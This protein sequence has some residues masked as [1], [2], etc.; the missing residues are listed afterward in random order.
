[1][2]GCVPHA[3]LGYILSVGWGIAKCEANPLF[4]KLVLCEFGLRRRLQEFYKFGIR[5][6]VAKE[7]FPIGHNAPFFTFYY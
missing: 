7:L 3:I 4:A 2:V 1:V 6:D 5:F